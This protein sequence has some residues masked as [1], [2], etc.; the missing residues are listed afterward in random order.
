MPQ[1]NVIKGID[2]MKKIKSNALIQLFSVLIVSGLHFYWTWPTYV[3]NILYTEAKAKIMYSSNDKLR[4][5]FYNKFERKRIS[6]TRELLQGEKEI[7]NPTVINIRYFKS[8]PSQVFII[9]IDHIPSLW[10]PLLVH[11]AFLF[12]II[13]CVR[14]VIK[15]F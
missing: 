1:T 5:S 2:F 7:K 15:V 3:F 6:Y 9:G 11:T 12:T 13:A 10:L 14:K 4:F 8:M